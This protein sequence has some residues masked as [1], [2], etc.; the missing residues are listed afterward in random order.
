[1]VPDPDTTFLIRLHTN[2]MIERERLAALL[3]AIEAELRRHQFAGAEAILLVG[4]VRR[5]SVE[6]MLGIVGAAAGVFSMLL[7]IPGFLV[8][9]K[10]L[11]ADPK[12]EPNDFAVAIGEV[13]ALDG[14]AR[15]TL[16]HRDKVVTIHRDEVPFVQRIALDDQRR[17]TR[18]THLSLGGVLPE[19]QGP[20]EG[21]VEDEERDWVPMLEA[22]DHPPRE[23]A[24]EPTGQVNSLTLVGEF[25]NFQRQD[26]SSEARFVPRD[27]M[28]APY[29]IVTSRAY[30]AEP[31]EFVQYQVVGNVAMDGDGP[32]T[33]ELLSIAPPDDA[34]LTLKT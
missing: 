9:L 7:A 27:A 6:V 26:G 4:A 10:Q 16:V 1:M 14:A 28:L 24:S 17:S 20:D 30:D 5:G 23:T 32:A 13:M 3:A 29:F 11:A 25:E 18:A 22:S 8:G 12:A 2:E 33:I 19:E 21:L 31:M 34:L 15:V